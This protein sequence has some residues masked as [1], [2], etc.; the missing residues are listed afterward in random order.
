MFKLV[1]IKFENQGKRIIYDYSY[2]ESISK[3]FIKKE[4]F[5]VEYDVDVSSVPE[6]IAV[7]PLL[8]NVLTISW[9]AG[10][11]IE[12]NEIDS[13]FLSAIDEIKKQFSLQYPSLNL[14]KSHVIYQS[15][16]VN[17]YV[18]NNCAMLFSGGVDAYA[19]YFRQ[20]DQKPDLITI[21][22]ADVEIN[23]TVQWNRI[24]NLNSSEK[25]LNNNQKKY[26]KANLRTF[27]SHQVD[28]LLPNLGWWG[29]VQHGL[30]LNGIIAP[31]AFC[32]GYKNLYIAS[33]Y[34]DQIDISWGSTPQID[35]AIQWANTQVIHD[36]YELKRQ[37]KIDFIIDYTKKINKNINLRVCYSLLNQS[38]NCSHCEKCHRTIIAIIA[39]NGNPNNYGFNVTNEIYDEVISKYKLGFSTE[40]VQYFWWEILQKIL[41]KKEFFVFEKLESEKLKMEELQHLIQKNIN[42]G[43]KK[44]SKLTKIK[45]KIQNTFPKLFKFYLSIRQ[46]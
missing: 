23:D 11:D 4:P 37:D 28:L 6:S 14:N 41:Q 21:H 3:F 33:S 35:N 18:N 36:G 44:K 20:F 9:F 10:F 25:L 32:R 31:L 22:G 17:N 19:T 2:D 29:K 15:K 13:I 16:K 26:V 45:F 34:T 43:L 7:I 24:L 42:Q 46:K 39:A 40:G 1:E 12:I 30:A 27:Y 8:A 5:F 38:V